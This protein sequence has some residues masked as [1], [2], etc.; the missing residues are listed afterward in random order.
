ML[1]EGD[2]GQRARLNTLMIVNKKVDA[3]AEISETNR[4]INTISD[5]AG[6]SVA[7]IDIF[8]M[9]RRILP[10]DYLNTAIAPALPAT[11]PQPRM[12]EHRFGVRDTI[13]AQVGA[14]NVDQGR[15]GKCQVPVQT[16]V[17]LSA[18]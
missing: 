9:M 11:E 2:G 16:A 1:R 10:G 15:A 7:F 3:I 5:D 12:F 6:R 18:L 4:S 13:V 17:P 14:L 8:D